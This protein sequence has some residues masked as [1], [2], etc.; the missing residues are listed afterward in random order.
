MVKIKT[1]EK[2]AIIDIG[3]FGEKDKQFK[4]ETHKKYIFDARHN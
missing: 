3:F 1:K 2:V 4:I